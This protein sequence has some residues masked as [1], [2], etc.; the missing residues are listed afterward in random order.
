MPAIDIRHEEMSFKCTAVFVT[1]ADMRA[2]ILVAFACCSFLMSSGCRNT[3]S[4]P[5]PKTD[6][7]VVL[8]D[9]SSV[10]G[11]IVESTPLQITLKAY[12]G[13]TRVLEMRNVRTVSYGE[14]GSQ[15]APPAP[16]VSGTQTG[17][18]ERVH[19]D[20]P[21]TPPRFHPEES[22]IST[23][24][25]LLP[26]GTQ[27]QV[28]TDENID[29]RT[30]AEGQTYAAEIYRDVMDAAG[31]VVLPQGANVQLAIR[32]ASRGGRVT[33]SSD[34]L[35]DLA[36]VSAGGRQYVVASSEIERRGKQGLGTNRRTAK[37]VGGASALGAVIGAIAG[38]GKGAAIG[39]GAGA[40]AGV[41]AEVLTKGSSVHIPPETLLTFQLK[42]P[43]R[44]A[45]T[46]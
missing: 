4:V 35:V 34:L 26:I 14:A 18:L 40:G 30:A 16:P 29:S 11:E 10:A 21:P 46:R 36:S 5:V 22:H 32:S 44:I 19:S 45:P 2:P 1:I 37:Y 12:D 33:G 28:R 3:N 6:V 13:T 39:A 43:L 23:T 42:Q 27:V 8:R 7:T 38:H 17:R 15:A 25:F 20:P 9:G 41:L 31:D 24:T